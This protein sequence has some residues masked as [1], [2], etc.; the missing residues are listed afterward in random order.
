MILVHVQCNTVD[1]DYV[2]AALFSYDF[3]SCTV[4]NHECYPYNTNN[5]ITPKM[6]A[7]KIEKFSSLIDEI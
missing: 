3:G 7:A 4:T 2:T 1:T 6:S 5:L